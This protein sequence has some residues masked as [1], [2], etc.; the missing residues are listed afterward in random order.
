MRPN[1]LDDRVKDGRIADRQFAEHL[2]IQFDP[3]LHERRDEPVVRDPTR[4][5]RGAETRDPQRPHVTL[6]LPAI[7][8]SVAI[9]ALGEFDGR[10]VLRAWS[11][12]ETFGA[13]ED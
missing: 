2:A 3:R 9:G 10:A 11:V 4:A 1:L 5:E 13:L 7:A 6:L 8:I 12:D